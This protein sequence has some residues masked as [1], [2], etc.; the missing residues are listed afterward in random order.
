MLKEP[1][2]QHLVLTSKLLDASH[3]GFNMLFHGGEGCLTGGSHD[4]CV[5]FH[6]SCQDHV[7]LCSENGDIDIHTFQQTASTTNMKKSVRRW[8]VV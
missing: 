5:G 3:K 7:A 4:I 2:H 8:L 1:L 6:G